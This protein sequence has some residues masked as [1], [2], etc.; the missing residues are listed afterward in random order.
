M[1]KHEQKAYQ[2]F[3]DI[4]SA[5]NPTTKQFLENMIYFDQ[6]RLFDLHELDSKIEKSRY[7]ACIHQDHAHEDYGILML[8]DL[9]D[10][11]SNIAFINLPV[12]IG[13]KFPESDQ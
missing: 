12:A 5:A 9:N 8:I 6:G 2:V 11:S 10:A 4:A 7:F 3:F 1:D 13:R